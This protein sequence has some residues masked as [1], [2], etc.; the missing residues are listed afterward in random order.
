MDKPVQK[1]GGRPRL[2]AAGRRRPPMTRILL[3]LGEFFLITCLTGA[4]ASA[5]SQT[6][7]LKKGNDAMQQAATV[8]VKDV[9]PLDR[10]LPSR[11]ET[12]T[13]GLG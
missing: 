6:T 10:S 1:P 9:P 7:Q 4:L 5:D 13:F 12:F 11:V 8:T 2:A 3:I